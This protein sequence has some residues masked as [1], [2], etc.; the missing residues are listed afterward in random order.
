MSRALLLLSRLTEIVEVL[1]YLITDQY[2]A[3]KVSEGLPGLKP[4]DRLKTPHQVAEME[5]RAM[6]ELLVSAVGA[7]LFLQVQ[8]RQTFISTGV[9]DNQTSKFFSLFLYV[10]TRAAV[11]YGHIFSSEHFGLLNFHSNL[12]LK[13]NFLPDFPY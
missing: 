12:Y 7:I 13:L 5:E 3:Q 1:H 11:T 9:E 10:F 6:H 8:H 4:E 2:R